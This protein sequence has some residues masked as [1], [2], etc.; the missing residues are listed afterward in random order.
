MNGTKYGAVSFETAKLLKDAGF[1]FKTV[2][3]YDSEGNFYIESDAGSNLKKMFFAPILGRLV[4]LSAEPI[5]APIFDELFA[6]LPMTVTYEGN[7]Y[8]L[9]VS[10]LLD[11]NK[12]KIVRYI[13]VTNRSPL[14]SQG[15]IIA[16]YSMN[17]LSEA[18]ATVLLLLKTHLLHKKQK[19]L[20]KKK[21][22]V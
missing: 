14:V 16:E 19:E 17:G 12:V 1:K 11:D 7:D 3:G 9:E 22:A 8:I 6:Q 5:P 15:E 20:N 18:A 10:P 21:A 13:G 2:F 4:Y